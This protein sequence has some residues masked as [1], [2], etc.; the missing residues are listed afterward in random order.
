MQRMARP[1]RSRTL[2]DVLFWAVILHAIIYAVQM[3]YG[4]LWDFGL[5]ASIAAR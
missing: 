1:R 4:M 5:F 3:I 2:N